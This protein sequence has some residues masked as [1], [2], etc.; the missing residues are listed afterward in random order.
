MKF[1]K[2]RVSPEQEG[3]LISLGVI[4]LGNLIKPSNRDAGNLIQGMGIGSGAGTIAHKIDQ[5]FPNPIPHHD[6]LALVSLPL[7]FI[8]DKADIIKD[9]DISSNLYGIGI[10]VLAEHLVGE[11]CSICSATYCKNGEKLC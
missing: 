1:D 7:I 6:V 5:E 8:L 2:V 3:L 10:G 4:V 9:K 11:G